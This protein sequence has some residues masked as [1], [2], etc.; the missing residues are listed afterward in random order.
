[1]ATVTNGTQQGANQ[2]KGQSAF[3][4]LAL[5]LKVFGG[6]VLTAFKRRAVTMDK[7]MVRTIQSG[8]SAQ[9]PV[10]GRTAGFYLAPG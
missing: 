3:D 1:M 9:F 10:M 7:H 4:K 5:F 8:K 2:G 6:E